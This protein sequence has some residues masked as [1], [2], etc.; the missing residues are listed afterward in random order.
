MRLIA[1]LVVVLASLSTLAAGAPPRTAPFDEAAALA[2]ARALQGAV[3]AAD[4]GPLWA[5]FD[6][7]MRS[8]LRDSAGF[9]ATLRAIADQTGPLDSCLSERVERSGEMLVYLA[10]CRF[11]GV[12]APLLL[13]FAFDARG[14]VA[15]FFVKPDPSEPP[16][17]AESR[18]LE[19]HNQTRLDFP[20]HGEWTVFWGGRTVEQNRH[21]VSRDQRFAYDLVMQRAGS[22]HRGEGKR[23]EDYYCYGQPILAPAVGQVV[24]AQ[25]GRPDQVPGQMDPEHPIGN[26]VVIAHGGGEFSLLAHL[27]PGRMRVVVGDS[28]AAGD[29]LGWC[30]NSGNSSEPHLHFHLQNGPEPLRGE[31]LPAAFTDVV[32]D[33]QRRALAELERGQRVRR[34]DEPTAR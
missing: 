27:Q 22:T 1:S 32:I 8:A 15:G 34:A 31:G 2:K 14:R 25:E 13:Q 9:A 21:A 12:T 26:G 20:A 24:W 17:A 28:V 4:P 5:E 16:R 19:Y 33:G 30:G 29:T 11:S 3:R 10:R 7:A 18:F 23:V 6:P